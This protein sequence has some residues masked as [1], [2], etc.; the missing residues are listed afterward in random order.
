VRTALISDIHSNVEALQATLSDIDSQ[1]VD[2]LLCLGDVVGYGPNP[3]ECIDRL[4]SCDLYILG[5]HDFAL[6]DEAYQEG[7]TPN[8]RQALVWTRRVLFDPSFPLVEDHICDFFGKFTQTYRENGILYVHG[9][10][11]RPVEEY[12]FPGDVTFPA[13]MH[14]LFA[15]I[16]RVCFVGHTHLPGIFLEELAFIPPQDVPD[17]FDLPADQKCIVNIGSVGQ[18]RDGNPASCYVIFTQEGDGPGRVEFHRVAYDVEV[19]MAKIYRIP[20]LS[21]DL[22]NRLAAGR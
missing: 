18:P 7:F 13:K 5:N 15:L 21:N 14:A 20:D 9:S 4:T 1:G 8:A 2:R 16:E 6:L 3:R 22:G 12:I 19:T 10:P 11:R 17:G